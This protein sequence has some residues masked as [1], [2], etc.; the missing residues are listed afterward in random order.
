MER[1]AGALVGF[2][3]TL[4]AAGRVWTAAAPTV[5]QAEGLTISLAVTPS[6]PA[7][8]EG[9]AFEITIRNAAGDAETGARVS[10]DLSMPAHH[11][12][13]ENRPRV[14]ERGGGRYGAAGAFSMGG[15][16]RAAV[17]VFL[18]DGRR[19]RAEFPLRVR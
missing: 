3:V 6:P 12:M 18:A 14:Q 2:V 10:L 8:H 7:R 16:W 1:W 9:T 15:E 5:V 11:A 19:A 4:A 17:E 13:P